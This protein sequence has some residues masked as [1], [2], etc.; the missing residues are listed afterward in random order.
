[1]RYDNPFP[2][3]NPYLEQ[4]HLWPEVHN[5]MIALLWSSLGLQIP[6]GYRLA[7]EQRLEL[8]EAPFVDDRPRFVVP[9]LSVTERGEL[10]REVALK[11]RTIPEDGL[12]VMTPVPTRVTYLEVRA[13][14]GQVVTV[15]EILSPTNKTPGSGRADYVRKREGIL[16]SDV[17]LVEIDL[18]RGGQSMPLATAIPDYHY[19]IL[20]SRE[21]QRPNA[22]LFPF[23]VQDTIPQFP[24]PLRADD[25]ELRVDLGELLERMH[26]TA[27]YNDFVDYSVLPPAPAL[28]GETQQWVDGRLAA[29]RQ[30]N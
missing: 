12:V 27:R 4:P 6:F 7:I 17:N 19:R 3:M 13:A 5:E 26:H 15:V 8:W 16:A 25:D 10:Q 29:F 18:L 22:N 20:V 2:G 11:E 30:A 9:D 24:L 23:T 14:S 21:W 28:D 1:M